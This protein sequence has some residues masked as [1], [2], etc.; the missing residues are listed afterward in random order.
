MTFSAIPEKGGEF[1]KKTFPPGLRRRGKEIY[2]LTEGKGWT[3][4]GTGAEY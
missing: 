3:W 4:R 2:L 1:V